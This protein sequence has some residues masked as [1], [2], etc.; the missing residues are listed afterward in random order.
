MSKKRQAWVCLVTCILALI[1][2]NEALPGIQTATSRGFKVQPSQ[3]KAIAGR[4]R[5]YALVIGINDYR[6]LTHL[7]T[8]VNDANA[9]AA[10]LHDQYG[11]KTSVLLNP[12]RYQIV[13]ALDGYGRTL[14]ET[15][16]LLIYYAGHGFFDTAADRAYWLPADAET[17]NRANW[18][19]ADDI[20]GEAR[21]IPSL[22]VLIVSDSCYSGRLSRAANMRLDPRVRSVFLEKMLKGKSR[23]LM[24]SGGNEPVDDAGPG[25]HSV[26]A[27]AFLLGLGQM[28][29]ELFTAADLFDSFI[30]PRVG[31]GSEQLPQYSPIRN[32]GHESGDFVFARAKPGA[33]SET[34]AADNPHSEAVA[35]GSARGT[36]QEPGSSTVSA[37]GL[38]RSIAVL[39]FKN[40]SERPDTAWIS[41]ALSAALLSELDA[42]GQ[43][44]IIPEENVARMKVDFSLNNQ[45]S[46]S[47]ESVARIRKA[48]GS[49]LVVLGS[50]MS[51]GAD[52][53]G[54]LR[55]D[56]RVQDAATGEI[57][58][59]T[60]ENGTFGRFYETVKQAGDA[61]RRQLGI[62]DVPAAE[63]ASVNAS[64]P[65]PEAAPLYAEGLQKLQAYDAVGARD[66]LE[67]AKAADPDYPLTHSA[68]AEAWDLLGYDDNARSEAK[69]AADNSFA[70][71]PEE[72]GLI[73]GRLEKLS[74]EWDAAI[75]TYKSLLNVFP[76]NVEYG[77]LL[78]DAETS[79]GKGSD[80][81][82]TVSVLRQIPPPSGEDPRID[83]A[84]AYAEDSL[85]DF[86]KSAGAAAQA[87]QKASEQGSRYLAA[88]AL[89]ER[90]W[91]LGN[92]GQS[93]EATQAC[94]KAQ[95]TFAD[96]G[97]LRGRA[98]SLTRLS[99][100]AAS[101]GDVARALDL[102]TRALAI[103]RQIGSA[104]DIS[105]A[106]INIG[107]LQLSR[108]DA[109]AARKSWE[110]AAQVAREIDF[111]Q[112]LL[113]ADNN[114][115]TFF[116]GLCEYDKAQASYEQSRET[117]E[118]IGDKSGLAIAVYNLG[119]VLF[120]L[121]DLASAQSHVERAIAMGKD[122]GLQSKVASWLLTS[123]DILMAEDDVSGAEKSYREA[124]DLTAADDKTGAAVNNLEW[125][126]LDLEKGEAVEAEKLARQAAD[127]F[128]A[129]KDTDDETGARETLARALLAQDKVPLAAAEVKQAEDLGTTDCAI[130]LPL[131]ITKARVEAR[132]GQSAAARQVLES[133][134]TEAKSKKLAGC[135][136]EA[137]LAQAEIEI[138]SGDQGSGRS[139]LKSLQQDATRFRFLLIARKAGAL[140]GSR[141]TGASA[142]G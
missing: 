96:V 75:E 83:V 125:A 29:Q 57:V 82:K 65:K 80:A 38:R 122:A 11:F 63:T 84:E 127:E 137:R 58:A 131:A 78:A 117:A 124:R 66:L 60:G 108:G 99:Q 54:S 43:L 36:A 47:A 9:V 27:D 14:P 115:G 41:A 72:K 56:L 89:L 128:H 71:S 15:S 21:I 90:C 100:I 62:G 2:A 37:G 126:A 97:D 77:L 17:N 133:V 112:D 24:S 123:G 105:G 113:Q 32:S 26:F 116:Q 67:E 106:L 129:E 111:K 51:Q 61:L 16:N 134:L 120:V 22:H 140:A 18:I 118:A 69:F 6:F 35:T 4:S 102:R 42:G 104:K 68:L 142:G 48:L 73:K 40:I 139:H 81:L 114:L 119:G 12:T 55:L 30:Q 94:E 95:E 101:Q 98:R 76:D 7:K 135:E 19:S 70:L 107:D 45:D 23:T 50:Y 10:L 86:K 13:S 46:L 79:G 33:G 25:G 132:S 39:G 121:G 31:G 3:P 34:V 136:M 5:Y 110:E 91:A 141:Q 85:S 93:A 59:S 88:E 53:A 109:E 87:E 28:D 49:D 8:A 74:S 130:R 64:L 44:R 103:A 52:P 1:F 138:L 92:L 20:T